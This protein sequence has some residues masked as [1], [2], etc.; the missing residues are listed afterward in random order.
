MRVFWAKLSKKGNFGHPPKKLIT[1]KLI[2]WYF[3]VFGFFWFVYFCFFG[4]FKGSGHLTWPLN[5]PFLFLFLFVLVCLFFVVFFGGF[6]G[7]VRWP[8]EGPPHLTLKPS[9]FICFCFF[10]FVYFC[11][12][13]RGSGEVARRAASLGPK[14][15]LFVCFV[16]LLFFSLLLSEKTVPPPQKNRHC[17]FIFYC[18]PLFFLSLFCLPL[19]QFSLFCFSLVFVFPCFFFCSFFLCFFAFV[20]WTNTIF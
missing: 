1:E 7:Q 9:L 6:Q 11:F 12:S 15:S 14:P 10:W 3:C 5:P 20:S 19:V 18:F 2:I 13:W 16:F 17:L 8:F 4:G